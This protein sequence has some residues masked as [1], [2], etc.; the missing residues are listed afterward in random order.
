MLLNA[1][2]W[3]INVAIESLGDIIR[4]FLSLLPNSPFQAIEMPASVSKNLSYLNW[5]VPVNK[6]LGVFSLWLVAIAGFYLYQ[7]ILRWVKAI[8]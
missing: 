1:I 4:L 7:I 6:I 5:L 8:E 3:V 2:I